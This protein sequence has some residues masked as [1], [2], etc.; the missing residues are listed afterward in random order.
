MKKYSTYKVDNHHYEHIDENME[1]SKGTLIQDIKDM[2]SLPSLGIEGFIEKKP[3]VIERY[4]EVAEKLLR[5]RSLGQRLDEIAEP[6]MNFPNPNF[7]SLTFTPSTITN[8][9]KEGQGYLGNVC[10]ANS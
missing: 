10:E 2:K 6:Y 5:N 7:I 8:L 4:P 1:E 3:D 9:L